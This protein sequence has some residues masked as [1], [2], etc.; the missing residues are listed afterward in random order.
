MLLI[1]TKGINFCIMVLQSYSTMHYKEYYDVLLYAI[2]QHLSLQ[3]IFSAVLWD[4]LKEWGSSKI[5]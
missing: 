3:N 1:V 5:N 2:T 4:P